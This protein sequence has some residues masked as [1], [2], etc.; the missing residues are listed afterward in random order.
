MHVHPVHPPWVRPCLCLSQRFHPQPGTK[1]LAT[2]YYPLRAQSKELGSDS[3]FLCSIYC[4]NY[5]QVR[6]GAG[7]EDS[8]LLR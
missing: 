8:Y 1:N 6:V 4:N 3:F 5:L 7:L 2:G